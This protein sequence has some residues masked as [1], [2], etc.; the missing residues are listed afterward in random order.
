[1]I[2]LVIICVGNKIVGVWQSRCLWNCKAPQVKRRLG[3]ALVHN[4]T[5]GLLVDEE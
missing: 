1:M 2:S 4:E 5:G 3:L